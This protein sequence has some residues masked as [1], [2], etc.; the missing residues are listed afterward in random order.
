MNSDTPDIGMLFA[1]NH[2][3][4]HNRH[5]GL[6]FACAAGSEEVEEEEEEARP[7]AGRA[8]AAAAQH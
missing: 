4:E 1:L 3:E 2:V 7:V 5:Q 8:D 6:C